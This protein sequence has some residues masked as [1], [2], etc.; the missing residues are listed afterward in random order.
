MRKKTAGRVLA[1]QALYQLDLRGNAFQ[2]V[3]DEFLEDSA[4]DEEIRALAA[5][6]VHGCVEKR[7]ELDARIAGVAEHWD[8]ARMAIVDRCIL[9]VGTYELL[10]RPD[11]PPK[12]AIDEAI[13]L[14]KK[15]STAASGAFVN[16]LLDR[17]MTARRDS[18]PLPEE[19]K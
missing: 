13:R 9:R 15:F 1:V 16:G 7:D 17:I 19:D 6:L 4:K 5:E 3:I 14:A 11:V 18:A 10:H 2:E 8:I 12:V